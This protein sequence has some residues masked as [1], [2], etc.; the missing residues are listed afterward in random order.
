MSDKIE[1]VIKSPKKEK[2]RIRVLNDECYQ[3]KR[4]SDINVPETPT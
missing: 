2:S 1:P 3:T 4:R